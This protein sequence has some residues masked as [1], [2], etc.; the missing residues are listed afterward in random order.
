MTHSEL[1]VKA[2]IDTWNQTIARFDSILDKLTDEQLENEVAPGKNRGVYILGH[3]VA[4]HDRLMPLLGFG[5]QSYPELDEVFLTSPDKAKATPPIATLRTQWKEVNA[6]LAKYYAQLSADD[7]F[8]K[9]TAVTAD[10]F[11]KEP[12]RNKFNVL[13][14][15]TNHLSYHFGQLILMK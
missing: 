10:D 7:W 11:A 6:N 12:H 13:V 15:R 4:V 5:P 1:A 14:S 8:G 9:H 2:V 3:M